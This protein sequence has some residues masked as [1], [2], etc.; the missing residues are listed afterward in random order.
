MKK[1]L[2]V[3]VVSVL[4]LFSVYADDSSSAGEWDIFALSFTENAPADAALID[5]CGIKAGAPISGGSAS[6][7]GVEGAVFWAGTKNVYGVKC[8]LI[9]TD[10]DAGAGLQ[11]ALCNFINRFAGLQ[12]GIFN[13]AKEEAFQIGLINIIE[14]SPVKFLP[15][16]NCRF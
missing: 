15:I 5:I 13:Y 14:N 3:A 16:I 1:I 2:A 4:A 11:L 6:V 7:Y 8:S 12:L 10:G 9:A